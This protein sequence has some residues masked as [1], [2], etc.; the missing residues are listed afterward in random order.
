[1]GLLN[2]YDFVAVPI[3]VLFL[4]RYPHDTAIEKGQ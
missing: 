3:V 4:D 2:Q 1:M